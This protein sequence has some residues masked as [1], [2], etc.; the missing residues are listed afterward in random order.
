MANPKRNVVLRDRY[1]STTA[2]YPK[3]TIKDLPQGVQPVVPEPETYEPTGEEPTTNYITI[4]D[5]VY[6]IEGGTTVVAN[7]TMAGTESDLTGL[8]VGDTKY[9]VPEK[10]HM[11]LYQLYNEEGSYNSTAI[12]GYY[13]EFQYPEDLGSINNVISKLKEILTYG[14]TRYL[15]INGIQWSRTDNKITAIFSSVSVDTSTNKLRIKA[16]KTEATSQQDAYYDYT[17]EDNSLLLYT[18]KLY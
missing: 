7:P 6:K 15:K 5:T 13:I 9:K 2:I 1:K 12:G 16:I 10:G 3:V 18:I 17:I 8:Q 11:Y 4:G 14:Y